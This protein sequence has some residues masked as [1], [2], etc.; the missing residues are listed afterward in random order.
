M[1]QPEPAGFTDLV[2]LEAALAGM[3]RTPSED[4]EGMSE[5]DHGLQCAAE[6][7]AAA[8]DDL[9]LQI[10]GLVHDL[11][12]GLGSMSDHGWAGAGAVRGLLGERVAQLVGLH[13]D[14]KRYLVTT[15]AAYRERLTPASLESLVLQGG[16]MSSAE[17]ARFETWTHWR[18]ALRLRR[19]DEAAKTPGR[20][21]PGLDAWRPALHAIAAGREVTPQASAH[22]A[23]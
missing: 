13:V 22:A 14:A 15:D 4:A 16:D 1:P 21:V 2:A 20:V 10:A 8:P 12:H 19:A 11:G 9:E 23:S 3:A 5:L 7:K 6:L 18:D 17:M